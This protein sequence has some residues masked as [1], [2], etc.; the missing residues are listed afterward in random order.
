MA[1]LD[2]QVFNAAGKPE[3]G[4]LVA[5]KSNWRDGPTLCWSCSWTDDEGH[6]LLSTGRN[7][8]SVNM[9]AFSAAGG[10]CQTTLKPSEPGSLHTLR[11]ELPG[12]VKVAG[13]V[14]TPDGNPIKD[15]SCGRDNLKQVTAEDGRFDL[16]LVS[17]DVKGEMPEIAFNAA[18]PQQRWDVPVGLFQWRHTEHAGGCRKP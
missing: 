2:G 7:D 11:M 13:L 14:T 9:Y 12:S 4:A 15:V 1:I 3:A 10:V 18:Q 16:G 6:F 5:V 8:D 17:R